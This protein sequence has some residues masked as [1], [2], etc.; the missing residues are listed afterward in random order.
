M[1]NNI[2]VIK[3]EKDD[4]AL[5]TKIILTEALSED[6]E[7]AIVLGIKDGR[8]YFIVSQSLNRPMVL[9]LIESAKLHYYEGWNNEE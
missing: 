3:T 2:R 1:K 6:F 4:C 9:G 5:N 7:S 8:M